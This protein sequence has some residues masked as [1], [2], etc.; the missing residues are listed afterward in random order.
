MT[1]VIGT[2]LGTAVV[3]AAGMWWAL[4]RRRSMIGRSSRTLLIAA[5]VTPLALLSWKVTWSVLYP[6]ALDPWPGRMGFRCLQLS[7]LLGVLPLSAL[8]FARRGTDPTHPGVAAFSFGVSVGLCV[9]LF[10]DLWCPVGYVPHVLLGHMLPIGLLG[11]AGF[12]MGKKLL[13]P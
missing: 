13:A 12:C 1:L 2:S 8:L 11:L 10:V 7:L 9:A 3:A 6:R 5:T 4:N